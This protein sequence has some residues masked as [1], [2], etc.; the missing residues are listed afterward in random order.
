MTAA[1]PSPPGA[2]PDDALVRGWLAGDRDASAALIEA[3]YDAVVRFFRTKAGPHADDLVQR[4]FLACAEARP[5]YR[6]DAG[7]RAFLFGVARNVLF[8]HI[9]SRQRDGVPPPD[10]GVT[11][12]AALEP[13]VSTLVGERSAQRWLIAALQRI[14]VDLQLVLELY[15]WED[16]SVAE[17]AEVLAVPAGTVKSRLFRARQDLRAAMEQL[18]LDPQDQR[19]VRELA[20]AWLDGLHRPGERSDPP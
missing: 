3:H 2:P 6:G 20:A 19:S 14:P 11:S 1:P 12:L 5:S 18:T 13:G 16:L 9:R 17:L 10:F 7:F 8:E 15:Y 4:T